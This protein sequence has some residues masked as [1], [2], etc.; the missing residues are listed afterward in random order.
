MAI[1]VSGLVWHSDQWVDFA[2]S[3]DIDLEHLVRLIIKLLHICMGHEPDFG[4]H[5]VDPATSAKLSHILCGPVADVSAS[6]NYIQGNKISLRQVFSFLRDHPS[7]EHTSKYAVEQAVLLPN[8]IMA[9]IYE[10]WLQF[11]MSDTWSIA[12]LQ[13]KHVDG[14]ALS[15]KDHLPT[16]EEEFDRVGIWEKFMVDKAEGPSKAKGQIPQPRDATSGN[17]EMHNLKDGLKDAARSAK[18]LGEDGK[19]GCEI[20]Y[21]SYKQLLGS[22]YS[23][24][25]LSMLIEVSSR[26]YS[27]RSQLLD[28]LY[29]YS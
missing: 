2:L 19:L 13:N 11:D 24:L 27:D 7:C 23:Y 14:L 5:Q 3:K 21:T 9:S 15:G 12:A 22:R 20:M 4:L 8:F 10:T 26:E 28:L 16:L 17:Y 1:F 6:F 18:P 25:Y 29:S